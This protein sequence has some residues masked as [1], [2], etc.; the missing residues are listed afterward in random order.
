MR[1][2][3]A[4]EHPV[5]EA[6]GRHS[7]GGRDGDRP[8]GGRSLTPGPLRE[9]PFD[10]P[11]HCG[12]PPCQEREP[13]FLRPEDEPD[14]PPPFEE[15]PLPLDE[16]R[17]RLDDERPRALEDERRDDACERVDCF[18][19][20]LPPDDRDVLRFTSP[21]SIS[22]RQAPVS[23]WDI[24]TY[25]LKRARSARTARLTWRIPR[26]AFSISEPGCT[27]MFTSTRVRRGPSSWN[28]TTPVWVT[29]SVTFHLMRWPS[30]FSTISARNCFEI[31]QIFVLK[32]MCSSSSCETLSRRCMNFGHSSYCVH[33]SYTVSIGAPMSMACW[34]G[35]RRPLP[36]P[37]TP[38]DFPPL[39]GIADVAASLAPS[40]NFSPA[41]LTGLPPSPSPPMPL[42]TFFTPFA[43]SGTTVAM[44]TPAARPLEP[45]TFFIRSESASPTRSAMLLAECLSLLVEMLVAASR[46]TLPI[47]APSTSATSLAM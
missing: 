17:L 37:G 11:S 29:P 10:H 15:L 28:V 34:I 14:R 22:P 46:T 35:M 5:G 13:L 12:L 4:T 45:E 8:G 9:H 43:A 39:P 31:P 23:S 21:S 33:V 40:P 41:F 42:T 27:S 2:R 36:T 24:S 18:E 47:A 7:G 32:A 44:P 6:C 16:L 20:L 1:R 19:R 3:L 26:A 30:S 38:L 25:A